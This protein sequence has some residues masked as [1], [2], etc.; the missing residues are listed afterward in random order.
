MTIPT[1]GARVVPEPVAQ[2]RALLERIKQLEALNTA[3]ACDVSALHPDDQN[4]LS[5][6]ATPS[7]TQHHINEQKHALRQQI[8]QLKVQFGDQ[9]RTAF[10]ALQ[11]GDDHQVLNEEGL[12]FVDPLETLPDSPP[13]SPHWRAD[14]P[15]PTGNVLG[16]VPGKIVPFDPALR[17]ED[18]RAWIN[19]I[20]DE[21]EEEEHAELA[22]EEAEKKRQRSALTL[23]RGFLQQSTKP[24]AEEKA[25]TPSSGET[26]KQVR[27]EAPESDSE[28]ETMR[29]PR[30][31]KVPLGMDPEDAGVHE[32]AARIVDLLGP[33]V[34][35]GHPNA[36]R[37]FAEMKAAEPQVVQKAVEPKPAPESAKPAVGEA[38]VERSAE[39]STKRT[40]SSARKPSAFKQR[41][42]QKQAEGSVPTAPQISQGV[43]AIE[44]AGRTDDDLA[45]ARQKQGLPPQIPH[46]RP[47][48]AYA[49]KLAQR[50]R[51][52]PTE[53]MDEDVPE[54]PNR[55]VRFGGEEVRHVEETDEEMD[56][57]DEDS[58]ADA[59]HSE[60]EMI[61]DS[62]D[63]YDSDDLE[64]LKPTMR[65]HTDDAFWNEDLAREYAEAKA[66]LALH[67][68]P[69]RHSQQD[70][71]DTQEKYGI[72]SLSNERPHVSRFKAARMSGERV[73]DP[74]GDVAAMSANEK[75]LMVLPSLAPVRY[76]KPVGEGEDGIDLDGESDDD[77]ERLHALMRARLSMQHEA[78][79]SVRSSNEPPVVGKKSPY[80]L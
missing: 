19:S 8:A 36:E 40:G 42:M 43:S 32:E 78:Q 55:R 70:D 20:I 22:K 63:G 62:D 34:I 23:R 9:M 57:A 39:A 21:L 73:P 28:P 30:P 29:E 4:A 64:A 15:P 66:R 61:W 2:A 75:P 44:R 72:A 25:S 37:I 48:K 60:D 79:E 33:E 53:T 3:Q 13:E 80:T 35:R 56:I 10:Q 74:N 71:D 54:K 46:A 67:P 26:K 59:W 69:S 16:R 18:R 52:K 11:S 38:I 14:P 51:G 45:V 77:D 76:P 7:E 1:P 27:I 5:H 24:V 65:E 58:D 12:P 6:A 47:T 31:K 68:R 41:K 49:A 17:G 50:A